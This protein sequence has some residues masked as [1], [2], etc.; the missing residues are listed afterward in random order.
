M[1]HYYS[2]VHSTME[3][4]KQK[5]KRLKYLPVPLGL[6]FGAQIKICQS[7]YPPVK[8][9]MITKLIRNSSKA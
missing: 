1:L 5:V 6:T 8:R 3:V 9:T 7:L 2:V 4:N